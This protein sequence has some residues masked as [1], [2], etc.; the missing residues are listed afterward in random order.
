VRRGA[1]GGTFEPTGHL[2]V[3]SGRRGSPEPE[4]ALAGERA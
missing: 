2:P 4:L 3:L 1:D